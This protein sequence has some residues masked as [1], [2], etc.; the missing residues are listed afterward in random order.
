MVYDFAT[1]ERMEF[2]YGGIGINDAADIG[3][4]VALYAGVVEGFRSDKGLENSYLGTSTSAQ[5]GISADLLIGLG[6]GLGGFVSHSDIKVNGAIWYVGG[7]LSVDIF[8]GA[9]A[10]LDLILMYSPQTTTR[11]TYVLED[12]SIDRGGLLIDIMSGNNTVRGLDLNIKSPFVAS[13]AFGATLAMQASRAYE[14]IQNENKK[15][16]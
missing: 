10:N 6:V 13:R 1:M 3:G 2:T 14:E 4:G 7:S 9:D 8:E 16:R 12:G 15:Y 11:K 5:V